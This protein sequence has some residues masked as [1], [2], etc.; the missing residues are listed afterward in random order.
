MADSLGCDLS[1][2]KIVIGGEFTEVMIPRN[3]VAR[4]NDDGSLIGL[5]PGSGATGLSGPSVLTA[6]PRLFR[7]PLANLGLVHLSSEPISIHVP[8]QERLPS[9]D[10]VHSTRYMFTTAPR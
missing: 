5:D 1:I 3:G 10:G 4:L 6:S 8:T 2:G 9:F 7:F